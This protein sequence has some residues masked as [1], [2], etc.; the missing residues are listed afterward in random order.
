LATA[1]LLIVS[2]GISIFV[3]RQGLG[4][5]QSAFSMAEQ[6]LADVAA[7]R[8]EL[9]QR[10]G[11]EETALISTARA[12][13][14]Q[15]Q[16]VGPDGYRPR[17]TGS[18][19]LR[20]SDLNGEPLNARVAVRL[21]DP[22]GRTV[23]QMNEST[24]HGQLPIRLP[25]D[26][27]L[28]PYAQARLE[29]LASRESPERGDLHPSLAADAESRLVMELPIFPVA[30]VTHLTTDRR[31]YYAGERVFFRSVTLERSELRPLSAEFNLDYSIKD[32]AGK[33]IVIRSGR[34]RAEGIGGGEWLIPQNANAGE[35]TLTLADAD[36]TFA[37]V[38]RTFWVERESQQPGAR[39][40]GSGVRTK[41]QESRTVA[42][43][44]RGAS[45]TPLGVH[46]F[47]EGGRLVA[48]VPT[49]VYFRVLWDVRRE[50][51]LG[52]RSAEKQEVDNHRSP[53]SDY[54]VETD[55]KEVVQ[56]KAVRLGAG[57]SAGGAFVL[58]PEVGSNYR[59][60][61]RSATG[62]SETN[63]LSGVWPQGSEE[64]E[65]WALP[66][67]EPEGLA[68]AVPRPVLA[69]GESLDAELYSAGPERR[70]I[71]ALFCRGR[72][73]AQ[74][75]LVVTAGRNLIKLKAEDGAGGLMRLAVFEEG[76]GRLQPTAC[77]LVYRRPTQQIAVAIHAS[78]SQDGSAAVERNPFRSSRVALKIESLN[79]SSRHEPSWFCLSVCTRG[80]EATVAASPANDLPGSILL[81]SE[82][83]SLTP[84]EM[85]QIINAVGGSGSALDLLLGMYPGSSARADRSESLAIRDN[86][87]EAE[88]KFERAM[89]IPFADLRRARVGEDEKLLDEQWHQLE[90]V[91]SAAQAWS[92][93]QAR[94]RAAIRSA[95]V[96]VVSIVAV[97]SS[98]FLIIELA[99][100]A[101]GLMLNWRHLAGG[102]AGVLVV[103][104]VL[105]GFLTPLRSFGDLPQVGRT[106]GLALVPAKPLAELLSGRT[107]GGQ[108][109]VAT[110]PSST[111]LDQGQEISSR[112]LPRSAALRRSPAAILDVRNFDYAADEAKD[113]RSSFPTTILWRPAMVS[114][115]GTAHLTFEVPEG[116]GKITV[117]VEAH[118]ASGRLGAGAIDFDPGALSDK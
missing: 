79:E 49:R 23:F 40:H 102:A 51:A 116:T 104:V 93:Y 76:K 26:L 109:S 39:G 108:A 60:R 54:V 111:A 84:A 114:P 95:L 17:Q 16:I 9:V 42:G 22:S 112:S 52:P 46:F 4:R 68:L 97:I 96:A 11:V 20:A 12:R 98:I 13:H 44:S 83:P 43:G 59:L 65:G 100:Y 94:S 35:Y 3:Y 74:Q 47:P 67:A 105:L 113:H 21:C 50:A 1:A 99:R 2:I 106:G 24:R 87:D 31:L 117:R 58:T 66:A 89:A 71:V 73:V 38:S 32:P 85:D 8:E 45:A 90:E 77:R 48:G 5:V 41:R 18:Y 15:L 36:N 14:L 57:D 63:Q 103:P 88:S 82:V 19:L 61:A 56:V 69:A 30:Y 75:P 27:S 29:L 91:R 81:A 33:S 34:T 37:P 118:S 101:R 107:V 80:Q 115:D 110:L 72:L 10:A 92:A 7:R 6:Q 62:S 86:A 78:K 70:T 28:P 53:D 25:T 64:K 55:G